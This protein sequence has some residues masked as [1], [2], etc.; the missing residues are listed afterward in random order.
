MAPMLNP[1]RLVAVDT[2]VAPD[3]AKGI[4]D[5]CDAITTIRLRLPRVELWVSP[6]V[7][8]E[9]AHKFD[10]GKP[11]VIEETLPLS[12]MLK[13]L[14]ICSIAVV[15]CGCLTWHQDRRAQSTKPTRQ[16]E[17]IRV[18]PDGRGFIIAKSGQPFRPWGMNYGNAGRLMEDFWDT[19]WETLAGDFRELKALGANVVRV[20]LQFGKFMR[21]PNEPNAGALKQLRRLLRLAE[22][23]ALRLDVTGLACYRPADVP[24]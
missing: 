3:F 10:V 13:S 22:Q 6:T 19:D 11:M 4:D 1:P 20:H 9:L 12:D 24:A 16:I 23:T 5:V 14:F 2:N 18:A 7:V 15:L 8:E 21:A 17:R